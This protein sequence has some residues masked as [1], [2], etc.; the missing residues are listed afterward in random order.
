VYC[1]SCSYL[2]T[3]LADEGVCPECGK[4]YAP[5]TVWRAQPL[6]S[7]W[8]LAIRFGWPSIIAVL[9][10]V[11]YAPKQFGGIGCLGI[12]FLL[13]IAANTPIQ[14]NLLI[15]SQIPRHLRPGW[16]QG[17]VVLGRVT[18]ISV[19]VITLL[20]LLTP[21]ILFVACAFMR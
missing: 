5:A 14:L 16:V 13:A 2:L 15:R 11:T 18:Y 20:T 12:L 7:T 1:K 8:K 21:L 4:A 3:G 17:I 6:P 10:I 9:A 19:G